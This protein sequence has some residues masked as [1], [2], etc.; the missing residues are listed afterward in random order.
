M[1]RHFGYDFIY[2]TNDRDINKAEVEV[3]SGAQLRAR[4]RQRKYVPEMPKSSRGLVCFKCFKSLD[5]SS[6]KY[7]SQLCIIT[8]GLLP[9]VREGQNTN[10]QCE[11]CT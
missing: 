3:V 2:G 10:V 11:I 1:R 8:V 6:A 4:S 5:A 9:Q 7:L